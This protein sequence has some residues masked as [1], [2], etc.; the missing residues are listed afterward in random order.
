[1][2]VARMKPKLQA[3]IQLVLVGGRHQGDVKFLL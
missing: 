1:M 3:L 2:D